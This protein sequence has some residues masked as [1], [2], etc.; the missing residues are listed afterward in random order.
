MYT[1][2]ENHRV[3]VNTSKSNPITGTEQLEANL[4]G[5]LKTHCHCTTFLQMRNKKMLKLEMNVRVDHNNRNGT[6]RRQ[7]SKSI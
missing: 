2:G 4:P 7:I 5:T 6:I 3:A 1:K